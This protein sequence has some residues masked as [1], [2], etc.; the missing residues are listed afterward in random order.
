MTSKSGASVRRATS[1]QELAAVC[2]VSEA[3]VVQVIDIFRRAGRSFLTPPDGAPLESHT[4]V[5]L[6][7]ESLMRCWTR[8][9][10]FTSLVVPLGIVVCA[11]SLSTF[12]QVRTC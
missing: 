12:A 8:R 1:I 9:I 5:D 2:E 11:D 3:E 7:H 4:I 6:S 10:E